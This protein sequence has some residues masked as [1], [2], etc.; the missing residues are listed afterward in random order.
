MPLRKAKDGS[1]EL[2]CT[3]VNAPSVDDQSGMTRIVTLHHRQA[4]AGA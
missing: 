1:F 3:F 4:R 2:D